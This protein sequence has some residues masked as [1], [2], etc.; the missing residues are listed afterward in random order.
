MF[1]LTNFLVRKEANA[2]LRAYS[3]DLDILQKLKLVSELPVQ[4][5]QRAKAVY[6]C[7]Q[8]GQ[9]KQR[10]HKCEPYGRKK[11]DEYPPSGPYVVSPTEAASSRQD[12]SAT[13]NPFLSTM[14]SFGPPR[15]QR[16]RTDSWGYN[17]QPLPRPFFGSVPSGPYFQ[18][19]A[20]LL[21]TS[22]LRSS[23]DSCNSADADEVVVLPTRDSQLGSQT[24]DSKDI[25]LRYHQA[26]KEKVK[27]TRTLLRQVSD[28][29]DDRKPLRRTLAFSHSSDSD[30]SYTATPAWVETTELRSFSREVPLKRTRSDDAKSW[31]QRCASSSTSS[32]SACTSEAEVVA[33]TRDSGYSSRERYASDSDGDED[34]VVLPTLA[35]RAA[36]HDSSRP[37][38]GTK[39]YSL[40]DLHYTRH[41]LSEASLPCETVVTASVRR[42]AA[43]F[44]AMSIGEDEQEEENREVVLQTTLPR[45]RTLATLTTE[46]TAASTASRSSTDA[47]PVTPRA[48]TARSPSPE[49]T[50]TST[51]IS[52]TFATQQGYESRVLA[53][54]ELLADTE[55]EDV[56]R[57]LNDADIASWMEEAEEGMR[58]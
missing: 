55:D 1:D 5:Q 53:D 37:P 10:Q 48:P 49:L 43:A 17:Q 23:T 25:L 27:K 2:A 9:P 21:R 14:P 50:T 52:Q 30:G 44:V 46:E 45:T 18:R 35:Q 28:D 15:E 24:N 20:E 51:D 19:T 38:V 4:T 11:S 26:T 6:K 8:C 34:L 39:T 31:Q 22:D 3:E 36:S 12:R 41:A 16:Q 33:L 13:A 32:S 54:C 7:G 56:F 40:A 47:K 29:Q 42:N 58:V 57:Y